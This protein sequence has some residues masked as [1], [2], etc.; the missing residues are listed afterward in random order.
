M[1]AIP[2]PLEYASLRLPETRI[3]KWRGYIC[4]R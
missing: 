4:S 3:F 1:V 2:V